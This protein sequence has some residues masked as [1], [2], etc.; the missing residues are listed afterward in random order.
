MAVWRWNAASAY[1]HERRRPGRSASQLADEI[2][3]RALQVA[4]IGQ[5][6]VGS[7]LSA[8]L[9]ERGF[10]VVG[11]ESDPGRLSQLRSGKGPIYEPGLDARLAKALAN[12]AIRFVDAYDEID[13]TP[14]VA[15]IAVNTPARPWGEPDT[16]QVA[17]ALQSICRRAPLPSAVI[18]RSTLPPGASDALLSE[19]PCLRTRFAY[20]P[21]F[22]RQGHAFEDLHNPSRVVIGLYDEA[23]LISVTR[24]F[25]TNP[26]V[27]TIVTS[28]SSAE[29]IK[30]GSN[31]FLAVKISFGNEIAELCEAIGARVDDV[32]D[33]IG[34]DRRIGRAFLQPG[35]GYGDSC[36]PKDTRGYRHWADRLGRRSDLVEAALRINEQ[37]RTRIPR[38]LDR[39][40]IEAGI[41]R[42]ERTA[43]LGIRYL[44]TSDD[45]REAPSSW[46]VPQVQAVSTQVAVWD[47][48]TDKRQ[49]LAMFPMVEIARTPAAALEGAGI[50]LVLGRWPE[51]RQLDWDSVRNCM[52]EP[53]VVVDPTNFLD[54]QQVLDAGLGYRGFGR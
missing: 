44:T 7:T 35:L 27:R 21:D 3:E 10:D 15:I 18:V 47:A 11:V 33:G 1:A 51:L 41:D 45:F 46:A 40:R 36:L 5:G 19:Y 49:L 13:E 29:L 52:S 31:S 8:W 6:Y 37:Q 16:R 43:V 42:F 14:D 4:V 39:L 53:G 38:V 24:V 54:E 2:K 50:A 30:Y 9:C 22:F 12:E 25:V 23:G 17:A 34:A 26:D 48:A 32:L 28:P 20:V